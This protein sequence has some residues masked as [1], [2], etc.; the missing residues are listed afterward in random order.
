[1]EKKYSKYPDIYI[2]CSNLAFEFM[3][4]KSYASQKIILKNG[5]EFVVAI[6]GNIF[7]MPGL[8]KVPA[9]EKIDIDEKGNIVGIF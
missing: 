6:A 7:T 3:F 1:M 2:A 8:P 5:A 9:S 4:S